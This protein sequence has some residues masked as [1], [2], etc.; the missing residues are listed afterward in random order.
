MYL[1]KNI[2]TGKFV[3]PS[4]SEKSYT[5]NI[6]VAKVFH[7]IAEA[8]SYGLCGNEIIV[9]LESTLGGYR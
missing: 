4:G 1:I 3:T 2:N 5:F 7:S 9:S 6:C 8:Q